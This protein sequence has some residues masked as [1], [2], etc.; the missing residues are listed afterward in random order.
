MS[1]SQFSLLGTRR[2]LPLFLTQA[3]GALNDNVFKNA[4]GVLII[5]Q[6]AERDGLN[7]TLLITLAAGIFILPFFLFSALAGEMADKF[8]KP[9]MIRWIKLAEILIM[10]F[11]AYSLHMGDVTTMMVVLFFMGAQ[12]SFFG[13]SKY[14]ILPEL[15]S[16]RELIGGNALVEAGTFIAILAGTI[17]GALLILDENGPFIV[18]CTVVGLATL[19][20][21][22]SFAIPARD[23][24]NPD[25]P[26]TG[27]FLASSLKVLGQAKQDRA[28]FLSILGISWFW[29]LGAIFIAQFP[30]IAKEIV[31]GD[32]MVVTTFLT[33]FS[34]GIAVGSLICNRILKG[35]VSARY[36]PIGAIGMTLFLFDFFF[37]L[38]GVD[39]AP[40][41]LGGFVQFFQDGLN[42]R[43]LAD[44]AGIAV[45]GG[46][47]IVPLYAIL[48]HKSAGAERARM[49]SA[50][51]I[52][53]ALFIVAGTAAASGIL[54]ADFSIA[55]IFLVLGVG[56]VIVTFYVIGLLPDVV[57]KSIL[58]AMLGLIYRVEVKG[59]E[60]YKAAGKRAIVIVNHVSFLDAVLL[61]TY[62]P[63]KPMFAV[64][65]HIAEAWW[66]KPFLGL[67]DA[68]PMD[69]TNPMATKSLIRE[70][71]Q[72]RHCV[73]FPEGRITV[74]GTLM[75]VYEG[76]GM[77]AEKADA[78]IVPVRIDGAQYTLFSRLKGKLRRR[79]FPKIS[80]SI[81]PP[82]RFDIPEEVQGRQRRQAAGNKLYDVMSKML[83]ETAN[84]ERTLFEA[85]LDA[86]TIHGGACKIGEDM[87]RKPV[88]YNDL[89]LRAM[90]LGRI[91][92]RRTKPGEN[93]G[94][95]LPNSVA[96]LSTFVAMQATGRVPA[97]FN[98]AS[99][100]SNMKAGI[101]AAAINLVV[102]SRRF[103]EMAELQSVVDALSNETAILYL[104]DLRDEVGLGAKLLGLVQRPF[105]RILYANRKIQ[106]HDPAVILFTSGSEGVP[107]GVVLSH[108]NLLANWAQ[109]SSRIDF[110]PT[111]TVFN[112]LP[113]FHSFG[114][115]GGTL[116]PVLSGIRTFL[117]PSPLHYRIVPPMVYDTNA[118]ILFGTDTFLSGY[119]RVSHPYDFYSV[120]YVFAGAEKVKD[121]TRRTWSEKFGLRILEGYGATETAPVIAVNTP[122][123]YKAG[124]VGRILPSLDHRLEAVP[125]IDTGG[126]LIV[127][128]PNVMLGYLR[129]ENPGVLERTEDQTYDTGDIVSID[130]DGFVSIEG[131]A[132][133]FAKLAGEMVSLTAVEK[134]LAD[135]WPSNNHAVVAVP[136]QR[137]GEQMVLVTDKADAERTALLDY[138]RANGITELMIP[139][140]I[141]VV[142]EL[143]VL[144][145][146]KTDYVSLNEMVLADV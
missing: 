51:N 140:E 15:L 133:R 12:S 89:V 29:L 137:K 64:N 59:M 13:P 57:I 75:K 37:V 118:T 97:M 101:K 42:W 131:R 60:N 143:P 61:A 49:I 92:D 28:I 31:G 105:A 63:V 68:F 67:V 113:M 10:G 52:M 104:E 11:G 132:K 102:T 54:A 116:L 55:H 111:D 141:R 117:Y 127:S 108:A 58:K 93:I 41:T 22:A 85:I 146:G 144:G 79:W 69:P 48:Q 38:N 122:M 100:A 129:V 110:N 123:H 72:D 16:P 78:M 126:R 130:E 80:I 26:L 112:A 87:E 115:T 125:G 86:R 124:T 134:W 142:S 77:V 4:L 9:R 30:A 53:N 128:G 114:L 136:D 66:V 1:D 103:V 6:I 121:E 73:I 17:M 35:E 70:M 44:L 18:A 94:V 145:T 109:L 2:F 96:T 74:T 139:K 39:Q 45:F 106:S 19:G 90:I 14:S 76:P 34:V 81:L 83:F 43:I 8:S 33:I 24:A 20:W 50:N 32:E 71:Q 99:G 23:A 65:T 56:S 82:Q 88:T 5:F 7:G 91:L 47:F 107:K 84:S 40:E 120:R 27:N 62:L 36:V 3:L 98:F 95:M 46:L 25:L 21:V 138:A 119:A 135:A